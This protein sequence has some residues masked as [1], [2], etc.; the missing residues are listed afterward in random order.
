M[1]KTQIKEIHD[2]LIAYAAGEYHRRGKV[3]SDRDEIDMIIAGINMLGEELLD[4]TVSRNYFS[5]IYNAVSNMIFVLSLKGDIEDHNSA[6]LEHLGYT[7]HVLTGQSIDKII[8]GGVHSFFKSAIA[9]LKKDGNSVGKE[10]KL[11]TVNKKK[12]PVSCSFSEIVNKSNKLEGYLVVAEDITERKETEKII[13]RTIVETQDSEQKRVADDL[14]DSMGQELSTVKLILTAI[15]E[16]I[17]SSDKNFI[18][19]FETCKSLLDS[20]I[21][22]IRAICFDLMPASLEKGGIVAA[23]EELVHRQGQHDLMKFEFDPPEGNL[24]LNRPM[25]IAMYRVAQEFVGNSIKYS[26][27]SKISLNLSAGTDYIQFDMQDNGIGFELRGNSNGSGRGL[28]NMRSRV[29]AY[30]GSFEMSSSPQHGTKLSVK[31][32]TNNRS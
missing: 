7:S 9:K 28:S 10:T 21:Q 8:G 14:H 6:V 16:N 19:A 12:V 25:E 31:F 27:A 26:K 22:N 18:E 15:N 2:L 3:S 17:N 30:N 32:D 24:L 13:L 11:I 29:E 20:S 5:G 1:K 23:L 4:T